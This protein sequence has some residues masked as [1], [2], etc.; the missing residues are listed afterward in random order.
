LDKTIAGSLGQLLTQT[1]VDELPPLAMDHAAMLISSTIASAAAGSGIASTRIIRALARE[2]G[3]TPEAT[4]W[5]DAGPA[6]PAVS[7]ARVNAVQSDSAASD[8]SH[9]RSVV[10]AGTNLVAA[11]LAL[12]ERTGADG[13]DVLAAIV[14]GYEAVG[15]IGKAIMPGHKALGFH[16]CIVAIFGSA[17]AAAR[18]LGADAQQMAHTLALAASSMGGLQVA[19]ETSCAREYYAGNASLLGVNAALAACR[20]YVA[21]ESVF[22]AKKGF[23]AVYGGKDFERVTRDWGK[24]WDIVTD[25]GI[26]LVPGGHGSHS[27]GEAA[28]NAAREGNV[29]ADEVESITLSRPFNPEIGT[30][31][32]HDPTHPKD[33]IG[34]AHSPAYFA[35]AGVADKDYSWIHASPEKIADP[36]IHQ[37]IDK[38]RIGTPI[39]ENVER[40]T[41][42][43]MVTIKMRD[44][45]TYSNTVYAPRGSG[46]RGLE[47]ADVDDKYRAL[48]PMA[49]L[50]P[51]RMEDSI[52]VIHNFRAVKNVSELTLLLR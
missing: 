14:L 25:I 8:D 15:R 36:V 4:I 23:F 10:H 30:K 48:V 1:T 47:W 16:S 22:E 40:F 50:D 33:L 18:L 34:V 37:L 17:V 28:A 42:G 32:L 19:A 2:Q 26:K 39:T 44:G 29:R 11:S 46:M 24:Q 31:V 52:K 41:H 21:E 27:L 45:K 7:A 6:L 49:G 5:F 38:V 51:A 35:A 13:K 20:G 9:M 12:A 3:G 43:A